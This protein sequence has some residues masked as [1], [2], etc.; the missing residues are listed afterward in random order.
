MGLGGSPV[1]PFR[2][3]GSSAAAAVELGAFRCQPGVPFETFPF[4]FEGSAGSVQPVV[5]LARKPSGVNLV[6]N[7]V[8]EVGIIL[9]LRSFR[10]KLESFVGG[11]GRDFAG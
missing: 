6:G 10:Q 8:A 1:F 11:S 4:V 7:G 3:R 2:G 9:I 5:V